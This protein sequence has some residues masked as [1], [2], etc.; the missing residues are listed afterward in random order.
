MSLPF[1]ACSARR[2]LCS[3]IRAANYAARALHQQTHLWRN[4]NL[5]MLTHGQHLG[6]S[7]GTKIQHVPY[8][9]PNRWPKPQTPFRSY[10]ECARLA[11]DNPSFGAIP[12]IIAYRTSRCRIFV[13]TVFIQ[14]TAKSTAA[15][16]WESC[17]TCTWFARRTASGGR[18]PGNSSVALRRCWPR[19]GYIAGT[20]WW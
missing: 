18:R 17:A 16:A 8:Y 11:L 3:G 7:L 19:R 6:R 15:T 10:I 4:W 13:A 12:A 14:Y 2:A 5:E 9:R 20:P 1:T